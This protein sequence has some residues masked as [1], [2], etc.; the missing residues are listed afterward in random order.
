M[1]RET[2]CEIRCM[3]C[4]EHFRSLIHF[5]DAESYFATA[6]EENIQNCPHCGKITPI[7]KDNMRF[8]ERREDGRVTYTEGKDTI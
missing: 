8:G 1:E 3:Y 5:G 6:T 2:I 7:N 4:E